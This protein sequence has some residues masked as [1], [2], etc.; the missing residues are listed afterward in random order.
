MNEEALVHAARNGPLMKIFLL[1]RSLAVAAAALA[2]PALA[3]DSPPAAAP[4]AAM[5]YSLPGA[6]LAAARERIAHGDP[7]LAPV[8]DRL[9]ADADQ[10]MQFTPVSVMDKERTPPSGDKHDYISQAPYWWPDPT[11]PDGLPFIRRDGSIYPPSKKS[12][13]AHP[14]ESMASSVGTLGLAYYFTHHEPYAQHAA[15]LV[16]TWFVDP[17]TRM[18]PNLR[19]GQYIPGKNEGRGGG[20]LEMRHLTKVCDAIAL[21]AD[22]PAWTEA[23]NHA[24]HNWLAAYF[25][26]LTTS[27]NGEDEAAALNNHGSWYDVQ[28]AHIALVLGKT[29]FAKKILSDGLVKRIACQIMPNGRQPLELVRTKSLVYSLFNLEALC[30]L[31]TLAEHVNVD[32]WDYTTDD[33][34]SLHAALSYLAPYADPKKP[35]IEN[36]LVPANRAELLPLMSEAIQHGDDDA[37]F[38]ELLAEF[39]GSSSG[40][41]DARWRLFYPPPSAK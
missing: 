39:G 28:A 17:A 19:F 37:Q 3:Q 14:W 30:N 2:S 22:S 13:D 11:K 5:V 4:K 34:R 6:A 18:N 33:G 10:A 32:W 27:A 20:I 12:T 25:A 1:F 9:R 38:S 16:R 29:D 26:W 15:L 36:D 24:F 8:L 41:S 21:I 31:A 7:A 40:Q 23:D 35:W